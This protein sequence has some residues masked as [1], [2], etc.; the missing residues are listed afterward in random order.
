MIALPK[1]RRSRAY[2]R[3]FEGRACHADALRGNADAPG[4]QV[5]Q[6]DL[7]A[8]AFT[9]QQLVL[10]HRHVDEPERA[11]V[12]CPLPKLVL[13]LVDF[14]SGCVGRNNKRR[15]PTLAGLY[16]R[17][18]KHDGDA[19]YATRGDE[20]LC[21]IEHITAARSLGARADRRSV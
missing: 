9:A 13:D 4:L 18:R 12:R 20:L 16:V 14:K 7:V 2:D 8:V 5:G 3:L 19:T 1:E 21:P 10:A 11:S 17:H 6:R 15:K